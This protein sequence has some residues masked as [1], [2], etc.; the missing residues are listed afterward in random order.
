ME[1]I[2]VP[3]SI[4]D[5]TNFNFNPNDLY[6]LPLG[7]VGEFGSNF[8]GYYINGDFYLVDCGIL[9]SDQSKLGTDCL[10]PDLQKT[11]TNLG[12]IKG[13]IL[14]HG[15]EDHIGAMPYFYKKWPAPIYGSTWTLELVKDKLSNIE[16]LEEHLNEINYY[17]KNSIGPFEVTYIPTNH[18]I[19]MA[20]CL[21]IECSSG[22]IFHTGDFKLD[23]KNP[24][25]EPMDLP[26]LKKLTEKKPVDLLISDSTNAIKKGYCPSEFVTIQAIENEISKASQK[27]FFTTFSSNLWR[28]KN[29]ISACIKLK[30]K[31]CVIGGIN[32]T[33]NLARKLGLIDVDNSLFIE[34]DQINDYPDNQICVLA[35]G[36]QGEFRS[37][38]TRI[39]LGDNPRVKLNQGD[40][41]IFSSKTIPGNE[42][43]LAYLISLC[44]K[45]GIQL[46]NS[47]TCPNIHVSGHGH[48]KDLEEI[49][50]ATNPK[51]HIP[52][53]GT[54]T[55][56][57]ANRTN[58]EEIYSSAKAISIENGNILHL[59]NH[60]LEIE[61]IVEVEK[62]YIDS[63]NRMPMT[64][65][66]LRERLRIGESG[67]CFATGILNSSL[68]ITNLDL[69]YFGLPFPEDFDFE[70][71]KTQLL[72]NTSRKIQT[73]IQ[74]NRADI[75]TITESI[76][77]LT[78]QKLK[79]LF[80]K[81]PIVV[82]K[83]YHANI[84]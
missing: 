69:Q 51:Y 55:H 26:R 50:N 84:V 59:S 37:A 28:I 5:I 39:I 66:T 17:E 10:I 41:L 22:N 13:F 18:S 53:H 24:F 6:I 81:K 32:K 78:R 44:S 19:P 48:C 29:L 82:A 8:M 79:S 23:F 40:T 60:K 52:V 20:C 68:N 70:K 35:S 15:H 65:S 47:D 30:R 36:S 54:F 1:K 45:K 25:E 49:L 76:R 2:D 43:I 38:L 56:L 46:V 58:S 12:G 57:K 64:K 72:E 62:L 42:K 21:L 73:L 77:I 31:L 9:F 7:G 4:A 3:N 75:E 63:F 34:E 71:F 80:F 33:I 67:A 11:L 14:T 83:I 74:E 16:N 27:V 61:G